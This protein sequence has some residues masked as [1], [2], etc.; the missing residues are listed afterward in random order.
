VQYDTIQET[1]LACVFFRATESIKDPKEAWAETLRML[2]ELSFTH[3]LPTSI[4]FKTIAVTDR[5]QLHVFLTTL[6]SPGDAEEVWEEADARVDVH[7]ESED[8]W[9]VTVTPNSLGTPKANS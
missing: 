2:S 4:M 3:K 7:Q 5:E 8:I 6:K 9:T 1:G